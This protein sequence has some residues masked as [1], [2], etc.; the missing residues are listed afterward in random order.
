MAEVVEMVEVVE[1]MEVVEE[2]AP[3]GRFIITVNIN[4]WCAKIHEYFIIFLIS[5]SMLCIIILIY[6]F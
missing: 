3:Y 1:E 5:Q 6:K 2:V 4:L